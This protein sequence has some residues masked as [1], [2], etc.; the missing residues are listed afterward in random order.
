MEE[1]IDFGDKRVFF[2]ESI[3]HQAMSMLDKFVLDPFRSVKGTPTCIW[4]RLPLDYLLSLFRQ[5]INQVEIKLALTLKHRMT[6][7]VYTNNSLTRKDDERKENEY[8]DN[9]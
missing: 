8:S 3:V 9:K 1:V 2:L 6:F 7:F 5:N 4:I